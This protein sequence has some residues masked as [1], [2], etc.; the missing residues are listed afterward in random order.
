MVVNPATSAKIAAL[1]EDQRYNIINLKCSK[2]PDRRYLHVE[3]V[4][5]TGLLREKMGFLPVDTRW[6]PIQSNHF[7]NAQKLNP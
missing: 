6:Q 3:D 1:A 4:W 5:L 2:K 7:A